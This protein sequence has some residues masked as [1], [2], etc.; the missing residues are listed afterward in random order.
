MPWD[1]VSSR[2]SPKQ[3]GRG[4]TKRSSACHLGNSSSR[5]THPLARFFRAR[6]PPIRGGLRAHE[7]RLWLR[8]ICPDSGGLSGRLV[9]F[10]ENNPLC[11]NAKSPATEYLSG[12]KCNHRWVFILLYKRPLHFHRKW[13]CAH[14]LLILRGGI[15]NRTKCSIV[16]IAKYVGVCVHLRSCLLWPPVIVMFMGEFVSS[17]YG[18]EESTPWN[19]IYR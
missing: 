19:I 10:Y 3:A 5:I 14:P 12:G 4:R 8:M 9:M 7:R 13:F 11:S 1:E 17:P 15:L 16:K 2:F 6:V 18:K